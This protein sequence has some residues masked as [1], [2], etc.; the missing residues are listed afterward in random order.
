MVGNGGVAGAYGG[1]DDDNAAHFN[2]AQSG[3]NDLA[4]AAGKFLLPGQIEG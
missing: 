4:A 3:G 2:A 1:Y